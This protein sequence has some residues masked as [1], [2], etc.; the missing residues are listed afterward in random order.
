MGSHDPMLHLN[1][2]EII[3][4]VDERGRVTAQGELKYAGV[5]ADTRIPQGALNQ[6]VE[7]LKI[8]HDVVHMVHTEEHLIEITLGRVS[9]PFME[10]D[11]RRT[12]QV[13]IGTIMRLMRGTKD[14][15]DGRKQPQEKG[16]RN[17]S[18]GVNS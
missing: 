17:R 11:L 8:S 5:I 16:Y 13:A 15:S 2:S 18:A 1:D 6:A 14:R 12:T 3:S 10:K 4:L 7:A 9:Q